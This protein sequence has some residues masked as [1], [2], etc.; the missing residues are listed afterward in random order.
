M[1]FRS[2]GGSVRLSTTRQEG[3]GAATSGV[4]FFEE[5]MGASSPSLVG[6]NR[7]VFS[8]VLSQEGSTLVERSLEGGFSPVGV[9]YELSALALRPAFQV[10]LVAEY[11]RVYE[12]FEVQV[13]LRARVGRT[14][15]AV[16][17]GDAYQRLVEEGA[18]HVEVL[19]FTD[20]ADL[21]ARSQAALEWFKGEVTKE[22]FQTALQPP[23]FAGTAAF[24][25]LNNLF[26]A[27]Q[28]GQPAAAPTPPL[29]A[30]PPPPSPPTG[31]S[32][33]GPA[34]GGPAGG[35]RDRP[36]PSSGRGK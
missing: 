17:I 31:P 34:G 20:D 18:I 26:S 10:R 28:N 11:S 1:L 29:T 33:G 35:G 21:K 22:F 23:S 6:D 4:S 2:R 13:G 12:H 25:E 8:L 7:A 3:E 16:E 19:E 9:V 32:S 15:T 27:L 14:A 5:V 30:P 36:S 24:T